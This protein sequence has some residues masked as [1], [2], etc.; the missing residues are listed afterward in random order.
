MASTTI[1]KAVIWEDGDV[2]EMARV[3]VD[4]VN[5]TQADIDSITRSIFDISAGGA[6]TEIGTATALVVTDVVFDDLQTG[7]PWSKDGIGYNFKERIA[8]AKFATGEKTYRVEYAFVGSS[9]EK[10]PVVYQHPTQKLFSS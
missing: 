3:Q 7:G 5:I 8:A 1:H 10:F 6:G 9:G 4:G 2:T